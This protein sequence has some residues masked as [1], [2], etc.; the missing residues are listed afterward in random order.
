TDNVRGFGL[1]QRDRDFDHYQQLAF[2]YEKRP[3]LWIEPQG[4]WGK[5]RIELVQIPSDSEVNDNVVAYWVPEKT[6]EGGQKLQ[7]S[8][9]MK[10]SMHDPSGSEHATAQ[11]T[12]IG[13]A[14]VDRPEDL[15]KTMQV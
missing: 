2:E 3:N 15:H 13:Y 8:Y 6:V 11:A 5:G 14:G 4:D 12:R 9:L 10:W 1:L 7:F